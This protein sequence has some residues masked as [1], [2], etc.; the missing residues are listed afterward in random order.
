[1]KVDRNLSPLAVKCIEC[2]K[3]K[4]PGIVN[5]WKSSRHAHAAVSCVDC[6]AVPADSPMAI[7]K[8]TQKIVVIT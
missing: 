2:H 1:M 6:H 8:S 5:D 4:T 7:K 3:D